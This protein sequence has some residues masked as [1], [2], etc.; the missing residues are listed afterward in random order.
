MR[1]TTAYV[2]VASDRPLTRQTIE[3]R[4]L[5]PNDVAIDVTFCGVCHSDLHEIH[6]PGNKPLVAGHEFVGVVTA[7][8]PEV[9]RF[10]AGDPVAVGNIIDS[11]GTCSMCLA[12]QEN[13]CEEFPT[14]TYGGTD[15]VDGT[16]T[17]G[18][19]ANEYVADEKFVY[20][21]PDKLDPAGVAPLMCAGITVWEPLMRWNA[22][23][24]KTIGVVGLGGLGH[25][26][27]KFAH[28]LG[29]HVVLFTTSEDKA[30]GAKSLGADEVV[31]S[32]DPIAMK[33]TA[34]RFDLIIDTA[35]VPHDLTP[36][37]RALA[38]DGTLCALGALGSM[39]FDP[40]ALLIGRKSLASA[41]S[42][43]TTG[44]QAMLD[45]CNE[46]GI[47]ADVEVLPAR[48]INEALDRLER[49]DVRFR[50]ALDMKTI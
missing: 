47:T 21:L 13:Y 19:F 7:I 45:F 2:A 37:I 18:G 28:A 23:P 4:D 40:M 32:K 9:S 24:G 25:L 48:D 10:R 36:Y 3:R 41:G 49:N 30:A 12:G 20:P 34:N 39:Q 22:G 38:L 5:R 35:S 17:Q 14:L 26:A 46:H 31:V 50:F 8:G 42:G 43:G 16:V 27:V 1:E 11:C 15:R 44:T 33:A 6:R 29:A